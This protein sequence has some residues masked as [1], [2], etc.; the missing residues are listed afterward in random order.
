VAKTEKT[1][2]KQRSV[3]DVIPPG[4]DVDNWKDK[5]EII[6]KTLSIRNA[7]FREGN[8]GE[9]C[10]IEFSDPE[11][12]EVFGVR[13]GAYKVVRKM[14]FLIKQRLLPI[15][16]TMTQDGDSYDIV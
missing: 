14:H 16:G 10:L 3:A 11:T 6:G 4:V 5:K 9:Y 7:E 1:K 15:M 2:S 12:D 13:T 8:F